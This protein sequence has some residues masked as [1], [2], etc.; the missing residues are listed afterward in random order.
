[1]KQSI[2]WALLAVAIAV[3]GLSQLWEPL[4][5]LRNRLGDWLWASSLDL[6]PVAP[7]GVFATATIAF[8]AYRTTLRQKR[9]TDERSAW[10]NRVQWA[11]DA[12]FSENEEKQRAGFKALKY[13]AIHDQPFRSADQNFLG[14]V[15]RDAVDEVLAGAASASAPEA[16]TSGGVPATPAALGGEPIAG[17]EPVEGIEPVAGTKPV[18]DTGLE[19]ALDDPAASNQ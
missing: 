13:M 8:V 12:S 11:M 17:A 1:M 15:G 3:G 18:E 6:A 9:E 7:L 16:P 19:E 14:A 5:K 10:W 2:G 4:L